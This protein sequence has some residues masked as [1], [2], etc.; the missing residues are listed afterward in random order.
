MK[1]TVIV[2]LLGLSALACF[3]ENITASGSAD[4]NEGKE[5]KA[6]VASINAETS[7]FFKRDS[8][9]VIKYFVHTDYAFHA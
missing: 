3:N 9:E 2:L 4:F 1:T 5:K 7:A 6:I 8:N